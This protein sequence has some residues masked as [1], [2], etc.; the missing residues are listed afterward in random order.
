[1]NI[2][3]LATKTYITQG[4]GS[5][6]IADSRGYVITNN[7]VVKGVSRG[8]IILSDGSKLL[9]NVLSRILIIDIAYTIEVS[10]LPSTIV[11]PPSIMKT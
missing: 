11:C 1:M 5:G 8:N 6:F 9:G 4:V 2:L 10:I 7:H 3:F